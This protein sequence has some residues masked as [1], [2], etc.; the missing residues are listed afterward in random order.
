MSYNGLEEYE[1]G[2]IED[3]SSFDETNGVALAGYLVYFIL[4]LFLLRQVDKAGFFD[5]IVDRLAKSAEIQYLIQKHEIIARKKSVRGVGNFD[6]YHNDI[7]DS[8]H[9]MEEATVHFPEQGGDE[10]ENFDAGFLYEISNPMNPHVYFNTRASLRPGCCSSRGC[11]CGYL[12]KSSY[13][14]DLIFFLLNN[15]QFLSMMG[16]MHDHPFSREERRL[17]Y[18]LQQTLA[19][20]IASVLTTMDFD[21]ID[22][23]IDGIGEVTIS[24]LQ[25]KI[26]LNVFIVSPFCLMIYNVIYLLF[27]CPCL[28]VHCAW[29]CFVWLKH[30]LENFSHHIARGICLLIGTLCIGWVSIFEADTS[31]SRLVTFALQVQVVSA[32][33]DLSRCLLVFFPI[34]IEVTLCGCIPFILVGRWIRDMRLS[35]AAR[36]GTKPPFKGTFLGISVTF[37]YC[38]YAN[39]NFTIGPAPPE[40]PTTLQE[41]VPTPNSNKLSIE[42]AASSPSRRKVSVSP[43]GLLL[44]P[45]TISA[46]DAE[47]QDADRS[48]LEV[49]ILLLKLVRAVESSSMVDSAD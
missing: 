30:F 8:I 44:A 17:A 9:H 31:F 37:C 11:C 42:I 39:A 48:R 13:I 29:R 16:C 1:S 2:G 34:C 49:T 23:E 19:F 27:S 25:Q 32:L 28:K 7:D 36:Y 45:P 40:T 21:T 46:D 38:T 15:S 6:M 12:S 14:T 20:A 22:Y 26:L 3:A 18:M 41:L 4:T 33:L 5:N 10:G 47:L 35:K 24:D 43:V